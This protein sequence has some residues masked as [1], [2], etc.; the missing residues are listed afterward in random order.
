MQ[1]TGEVPNVNGPKVLSVRSIALQVNQ[2]LR[3]GPRRIVEAL[4]VIS[5]NCG[6]LLNQIVLL[7]TISSRRQ[8]QQK[9]R[10][11]RGQRQRPMNHQ[12][13]QSPQFCRT[14]HGNQDQS[15]L[16]MLP[17][18]LRL[19]IVPPTILQKQ[20][21]SQSNVQDPGT[22]FGRRTLAPTSATHRHRRER[23]KRK[24]KDSPL[25]RVRGPAPTP[26][27]PK[28]KT[29]QTK[30]LWRQ[31]CY[32]RARHPQS[33]WHRR[34]QFPSPSQRSTPCRGCKTGTRRRPPS[35]QRHSRRNCRSSTAPGIRIAL[36]FPTRF[37]RPH[38]EDR[39]RWRAMISRCEPTAR[40]FSLRT[41][42]PA[43]CHP[44]ALLPSMIAPGS[45]TGL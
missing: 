30:T 43:Q 33:Q 10:Q 18:S 11:I 31:N 13:R 8:R 34:V 24:S 21:P 44:T 16:R 25:R 4:R 40:L 5:P 41:P 6:R 2:R 7:M 35:H 39:L 27:T 17:P 9:Q 22:K 23:G 36:S 37:S 14:N 12:H 19:N 28:L 29:R 1:V 42:R 20:E 38:P 3:K 26:R 32:C 15:N 45:G